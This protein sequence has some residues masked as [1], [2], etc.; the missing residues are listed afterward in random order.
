MTVPHPKDMKVS[1]LAAPS[2]RSMMLEG[3]YIGQ[4]TR[5]GLS[6]LTPKKNR[7]MKK[8]SKMMVYRYP[9]SSSSS[10]AIPATRA[11][12]T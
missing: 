4:K 8:I 12:G 2:F 9:T 6:A 5:C 1:Q 7:G 10:L 11:L 3:S